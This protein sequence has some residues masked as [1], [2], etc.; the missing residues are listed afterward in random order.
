MSAIESEPYLTAY[1]QTMFALFNPTTINTTIEKMPT[2]AMRTMMFVL[3]AF[4]TGPV[5]AQEKTNPDFSTDKN[6]QK[7]AG[8]YSLDAVEFAKKQFGVNLDWS[9]ESM[10][11]VEKILSKMHESY[12]ATSPRP[13]DEQVMSFAKAFGSYIGEVYRRNHGAEWGLVDINGQ[14]FPGLK[15]KFGTKFWPWGKASSRIIEGPENNVQHYYQILL[16]R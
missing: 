13:T 15:T 9:D 7:V 5:C 2:H 8:A 4:L 1:W 6:I 14:K 16:T 3:F 11:Q 10:Q 12:L